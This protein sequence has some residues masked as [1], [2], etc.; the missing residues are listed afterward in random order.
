[1]PHSALF[2]IV[3]NDTRFLSRWLDYYEGVFD[4]LYI[5]NHGSTGD[6]ADLLDGYREVG[7]NIIDVN[8]P[9]SYDAVWLAHTIRVF[10]EFLLQSHML[11]AYVAIDEILVP[12]ADTLLGWVDNFLRTDERAVVRAQGY[13]VCH[14][15]EKE[16]ALDWSRPPWLRQRQFWYKSPQYSKPVM[17]KVPIHWTPGCFDAT[18]VTRTVAD[19]LLLVH[20]HR[21][22]YD[23]CLRRHREINARQWSPEDRAAGPFRHN[24]IEDPEMLS[25]WILCDET[26][27]E[28]ATLEEIPDEFRSVV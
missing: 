28:Y 4:N 6:G 11:V 9:Q 17:G 25:R 3:Q 23:D 1:M 24:L 8:H 16:D 10:Q 19:D 2:T 13:E 21:I 27:G 5:L 15:R 14:F 22:D 26:V 7:D 12:R 18:N 20:L